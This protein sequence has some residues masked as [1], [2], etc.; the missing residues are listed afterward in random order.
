MQPPKYILYA[1]RQ[2]EEYVVGVHPW[3]LYTLDNA[4]VE[5]RHIWMDRDNKLDT[6]TYHAAPD[7]IL[8]VGEHFK[9]F[10]GALG[11][12]VFIARIA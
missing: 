5:S 7:D 12:Q 3:K 4:L 9:R 11:T 8:A 2:N 1:L 10:G 6:N